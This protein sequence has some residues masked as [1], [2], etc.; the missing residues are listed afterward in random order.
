MSR[1]SAICAVSELELDVNERNEFGQRR[2]VT[3]L[4]EQRYTL[5]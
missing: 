4:H 2:C 3:S 1:S 5:T